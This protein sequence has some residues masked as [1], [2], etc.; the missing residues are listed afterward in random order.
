MTPRA[1][2]RRWGGYLLFVLVFAIG[3]GLL[4]WWQW[5]RNAEA[6]AEIDRVAANWDAPARTVTE[7]LPRLDSWDIDDR[8][9]PVELRGRYLRDE[10]TLVRNRPLD[11][12]TGFEVLV[13]FRTDDGRVFVI[14]RGWIALGQRVDVPKTIPAAPSGRVTVV[15]RLKQGEPKLPGRTAPAGQIPSIYLPE[16]ADAVGAPT[17]TG[18]YGLLASETPA[19]TT[20]PIAATKPVSDL[21]PH[22]S[23]ALQWIAFGILAFI[24]LGWAVRHERRMARI[25]AGMEKPRPEVRPGRRSDAAEED[26]LVDAV[27]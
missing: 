8:W 16:M 26:A 25:E 14:D 18:A 4:S 24:G 2:L 23:Y 13:P 19:P 17:Y 6:Q 10:Q 1:F 15:A 3:C 5:A 22:I 7:V 20:R 11:G 9:R 12:R 27:R 21:G